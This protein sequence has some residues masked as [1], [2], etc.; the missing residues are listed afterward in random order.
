MTVV[1]DT[2]PVSAPSL[3]RHHFDIPKL[4]SR[5]TL[6]TICDSVLPP[7]GLHQFGHKRQAKPDSLLEKA[8]T[9]TKECALTGYCVE[10]GYAVVTD[11][12]QLALLDASAT[13]EIVE[14]VKHSE[15]DQGHRVQVTRDTEDGEVTT[16]SVEE[17]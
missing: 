11:D 10:S 3:V 4:E 1:A 2:H 15:K 14:V 12:D 8:E 6:R 16:S 17:V 5:A 7:V 9:H 13:P